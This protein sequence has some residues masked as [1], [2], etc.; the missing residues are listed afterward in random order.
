ML[1]YR[2]INEQVQTNVQLLGTHGAVTLDTALYHITKAVHRYQSKTSVV[3]R[4]LSVATS[5]LDSDGAV[6]I[7]AD[8]QKIIRVEFVSTGSVAPVEVA[9]VGDDYFTDIKQNDQRLIVRTH[10]TTATQY[11]LTRMREKLYFYPF[12]GISGTIK[13][14]YLPKLQPY[15]PDRG[16]AADGDYAGASADLATWM[17]ENSPPSELDSAEEAIIAFASAQLLRTIKNWKKQ[18]YD[19]YVEWMKEFDSAVDDVIADHNPHNLYTE[20]PL[21][22]GPGR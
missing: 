9:L 4:Q 16:A 20:G 10:G 19:D 7:N 5:S 6:T 2:E 1:S 15:S 12:S 17:D 8:I 18:F 13:V 14:H 22:G 11:M 3:K 21:D